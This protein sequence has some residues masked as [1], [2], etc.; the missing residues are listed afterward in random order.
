MTYANARVVMV[1]HPD[2]HYLPIRKWEQQMVVL[3]T[4]VNG[5]LY[6]V[7]SKRIT[8]AAA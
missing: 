8:K 5:A 4:P 2:G 3:G 7:S 1:H 6:A